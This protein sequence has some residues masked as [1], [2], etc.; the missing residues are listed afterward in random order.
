MTSTTGEHD[1]R[2]EMK[3]IDPTTLAVLR[4]AFVSI[5]HDMSQLL[6]RTSGNYITSQ[7]RDHNTGVYDREGR[8]IAPATSSL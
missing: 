4:D 6:I 5:A 8:V 7:L 1:A 2:R 3:K